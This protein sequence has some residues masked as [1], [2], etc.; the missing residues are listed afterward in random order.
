MTR[1]PPA[2]APTAAPAIASDD[3]GEEAERSIPQRVLER[4]RSIPPGRVAT[5]GQIAELAGIG[6]RP[7]LVGYALAGISRSAEHADVPWHRVINARGEVSARSSRAGSWTEGPPAEDL[8]RGLLEA[9]GVAFD[10]RG[11][12]DLARYRWNPEVPREERGRGRRR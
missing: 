9:E 7:R 10:E 3:A 5:Y 12:V 11:R 6:G 1:R 4:V 8:Q 2:V